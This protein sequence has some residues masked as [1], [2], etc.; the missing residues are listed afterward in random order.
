MKVSQIMTRP[1]VTVHTET[2]ID[3][4][5]ALMSSYEIASLPVLDLDERVV[6]MI[7]EIDVIRAGLVH[8]APAHGASRAQL[9]RSAQLVRDVMNNFAVCLGQ[10][11]EVSDVAAIMVDNNVRA[12]PIVDGSHVIGIVSRRD[13]LRTLI[14]R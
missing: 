8:R 2:S 6:G 5:A 7:S 11:A 13:V 4:A 9:R 10:D 1:V 3:E 14:R 12:V